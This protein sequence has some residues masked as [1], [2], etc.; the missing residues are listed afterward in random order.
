MSQTDELTDGSLTVLSQAEADK[1]LLPEVVAHQAVHQEVDAGV[2][3]GGEVGHVGQTLDPSLRQEEVVGV[4]SQVEII[5][6]H[7]GL[8]VVELPDVD[9]SP[10]GAAADEDDDDAEQDHE[11]V[12]LL[13][14][15]PLRPKRL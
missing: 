4:S 12:H 7:N 8:K 13:P 5:A 6:G 9:D 1:E 3:D 11:H 2:E 15:L 10:G 14:Q